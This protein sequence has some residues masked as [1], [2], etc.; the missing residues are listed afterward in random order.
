[1][2]LTEEHQKAIAKRI[3][4][5]DRSMHCAHDS[6]ELSE[7]FESGAEWAIEKFGGIQWKEYPETKPEEGQYVDIITKYRRRITFCLLRKD[8]FYHRDGG[9]FYEHSHVTHWA[10]INLPNQ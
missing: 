4:G 1:M 8:R 5:Y 7:H 6:R 3:E 9:V 2:K 10:E